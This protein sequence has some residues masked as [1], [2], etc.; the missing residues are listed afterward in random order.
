MSSKFLDTIRW[1]YPAEE[2]PDGRIEKQTVICNWFIR[3]WLNSHGTFEAS[4]THTKNSEY[5]K[6]EIGQP[7]KLDTA[8]ELTVEAAIQYIPPLN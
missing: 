5:L 6:L 1:H 4:M 8:C 7:T 3:V 2:M